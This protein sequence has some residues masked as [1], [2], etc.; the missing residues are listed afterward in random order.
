MTTA[1]IIGLVLTSSVVSALF[2]SFI[3]WKIQNRNY[4][5]EYYKKLLEK[6][7]EAYESVEDLISRL[8]TVV[9]IGKGKACNLFFTYGQDEFNK[10]I[11]SLPFVMRKSF[12]VKEKITEKITEL[13]VLLIEIDNQLNPDG[14]IDKQLKELGSIHRDKIREIRES[15]ESLLYKDFETL[16]DIRRFIKTIRPDKQ[17]VVYDKPKFDISKLD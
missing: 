2:T 13:N 5:N 6:R 1:E 8:I 17:F 15:I 14:D 12:W 11:I 4:R 7:L 10:F 16:H 9:I 3:N